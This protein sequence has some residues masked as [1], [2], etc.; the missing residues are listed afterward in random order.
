MIAPN[1]N[2]TQLYARS[3]CETAVV[4]PVIPFL[5]RCICEAHNAMEVHLTGYDCPA[6]ELSTSWHACK[7]STSYSGCCLCIASALP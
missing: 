2:M 1:A 7:Q 4:K 5:W 3:S 6:Q